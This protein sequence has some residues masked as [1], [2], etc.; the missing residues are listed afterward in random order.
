MRSVHPYEPFV[1]QGATKLIIGTIP[2]YRFC[3]EPQELRD[4]DVNFYY[5]SR[6]N[7]FWRLIEQATGETFDFENTEKAV[8]QRKVFL[9]KRGIGITDVVQSCVHQDGKSDDISLQSIQPKPVGRLLSEHPSIDTLIYTGRS[10]QN[11]SVMWLMNHYI[12]DK[13]YHRSVGGESAEKRVL[14]NG[15]TYRVILLYSPSPNA[16]RGIDPE[17]RFQQYQQVLGLDDRTAKPANN[18]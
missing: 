9:D 6:A 18:G 13:G 16:L 3:I 17:T 14:I 7:A 12:A 8:E 4:G 15:K 1:P 2:P 5:G 10:S 11:N